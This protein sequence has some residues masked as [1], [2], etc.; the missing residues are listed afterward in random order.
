MM[1]CGNTEKPFYTKHRKS[2]LEDCGLPSNL[3]VGKLQV[4]RGRSFLGAVAL[5]LLVPSSAEGGG[6]R[7][8][9]F[10]A[11]ASLLILC[12]F[13]CHTRSR[14]DKHSLSLLYS[15]RHS[16]LRAMA[17]LVKNSSNPNPTRS[18]LL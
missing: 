4:S 11:S 3:K 6:S 9:D 17:R 12:R 16:T 13:L 15:L 1:W 18:S 5:L 14:I 8:P 7:L 10:W 2:G